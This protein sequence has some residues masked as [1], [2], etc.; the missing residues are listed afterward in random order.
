MVR[1]LEVAVDRLPLK[2]PFTI[3]R[4]AVSELE[5]VIATISDG[6]HRGRGECRP[7]PRYGESVDSVVAQ[8]ES[9]RAPLA[10]GL[11]GL[12]LAVGW[13]APLAAQPKTVKIGFIVSPHVVARACLQ[14]R[15]CSCDV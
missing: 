15:P 6:A 14:A 1:T 2:K 5:L 10:A 7:Y 3:S 12:A 13:L 8:I 9:L 4:G 11:V